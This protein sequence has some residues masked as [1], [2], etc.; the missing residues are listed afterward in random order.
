MSDIQ[1]YTLSFETFINVTTLYD[2]LTHGD[3]MYTTVTCL[4]RAGYTTSAVSDGLTL[5]TIP[6]ANQTAGIIVYNPVLTDCPAREEFVSSDSVQFVWNR[7]GDS[8][9]A[10]HYYQ[11][12]IVKNG[13]LSDS[14]EWKDVG[15]LKQITITDL[16][17]LPVDIAHM[18]MIRAY[19][20][21][22]LYSGPISQS[23]TII[24]SPPVVKGIILYI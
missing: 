18:V 23:F 2:L 10:P 21:E 19:A 16:S 15:S 11:I 14:V 4:N 1:D 22:G 20:V 9:V 3:I 8:S 12:K 7:F 5:V 17:S 24:S 13:E 6:P